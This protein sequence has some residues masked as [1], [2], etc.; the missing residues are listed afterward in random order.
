M[1]G[2]V[3]KIEFKGGDKFRR[4]LKKM[5][6][7]LGTAK[8][9]NVGIMADARYPAAYTNRVEH[10]ISPE[11]TTTSVAQVA[12][13]NH[14]G[15]SRAPARPWMQK[16]VEEKGPGWG[17][18]L[19]YLAKLYNY[20]AKRMLTSLGTGI[21]DQMVATLVAWDAP[22]NAKLTQEIKGFNKPLIDE[23][24]LQRAHTFEVTT[25]L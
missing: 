12:F 17:E 9:V 8:A 10:R 24:Y 15:T 11:R 1:A 7:G 22:P 21:R 3:V 5:E 2:R 6:T 25:K 18:S 23:G 14:F 20:N 4:T 19:A 16:T 13:W